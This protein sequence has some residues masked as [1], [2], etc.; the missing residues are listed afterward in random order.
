MARTIRLTARANA[1]RG[2]RAGLPRFCRTRRGIGP[3][4]TITPRSTRR[5]TELMG[6]K[7]K[8]LRALR[9]LRGAFVWPGSRSARGE[10]RQVGD[11]DHVFQRRDLLDRL[12]EPVLPEDLVLALLEPLADA[13]VLLVPHQPVEGRE[14]VGVLA[15]LVRAVRAD[16]RADVWCGLGP[17]AAAGEDLLGQEAPWKRRISPSYPRGRCPCLRRSA[18][19]CRHAR[20]PAWTS[21]SSTSPTTRS[22]SSTAPTAPATRPRRRGRCGRTSPRAR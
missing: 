6:E 21:C 1:R 20:R 8:H 7:P 13:L 5:N 10:L 14:Q 4:K 3:V 2:G 12:L 11:A 16:E 19:R 15:R 22:P 18:Q 17:V 9:V